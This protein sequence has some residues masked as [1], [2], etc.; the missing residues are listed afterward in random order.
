MAEVDK[1]GEI[2]KGFGRDL[3]GFGGSEFSE[4]ASIATEDE[5]GVGTAGAEDRSRFVVMP[6][7]MIIGGGVIGAVCIMVISTVGID[8]G[9]TV[10][11]GRVG[12]G[13]SGNVGET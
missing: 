11:C 1:T 7:D 5:D 2:G 12:I 6:T 13:E 4:A 3:D 10:I 9:T 8:D